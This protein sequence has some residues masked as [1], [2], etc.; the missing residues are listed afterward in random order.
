MSAVLGDIIVPYIS[1]ED[2]KCTI[3]LSSTEDKPY[4]IIEFQQ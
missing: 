1:K 4:T 2:N 3:V